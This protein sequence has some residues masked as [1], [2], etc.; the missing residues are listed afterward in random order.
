MEVIA[1]LW[2]QPYYFDRNQA[3][4]EAGVDAFRIKCSHHSVEVLSQS[5]MQARQQIDQNGGKVKLLADL[6]EGK[7]CLAGRPGI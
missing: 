1:T 5:L 6:P 7:S 3:M 2:K 4:I